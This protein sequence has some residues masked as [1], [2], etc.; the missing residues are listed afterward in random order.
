MSFSFPGFQFGFIF[1]FQNFCIFIDFLFHILHY[2][3]YFI[4]LLVYILLAI[5]GIYS[6]PSRNCVAWFSCISCVCALGFAHLRPSPWL[7]VLITFSL[8]FEYSSRTV[9]WQGY[10]A[11]SHHWH[12][13]TARYPNNCPYALDTGTKFQHYSYRGKL[14]GF[15]CGA[16]YRLVLYVGSG[17]AIVGS[18]IPFL[19]AFTLRSCLFYVPGDA[20]SHKTF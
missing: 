2:L 16:Y 1:F 6:C 10:I 13:S 12:G 15:S 4:Q 3:S 8:S 9:Y 5:F 14:V 18:V 7:Q 19:A 20:A 11:V 17:H